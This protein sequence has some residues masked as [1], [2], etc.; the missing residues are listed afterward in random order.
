M[1]KWTGFISFSRIAHTY[2]TMFG[3]LG[4]SFFAFTGVILNH[5]HWFGLDQV[6]V[7]RVQGTLPPGELHPPDKLA[8]VETLRSRFGAAGKLDAMEIDD[9]RITVVFLQPGRRSEA[10]ITVENGSLEMVNETTGLAGI[11]SDLHK[12]ASTGD[13]WKLIIDL[14]AGVLALALLTGLIVWASVRKRR[15]WGIL[16]VAAGIGIWFSCYLLLAVG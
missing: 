5:A 15:V 16:A 11:V 10:V 9:S 4:M 12:G 8:I 7:R 13:W 1:A 14:T 6:H 3:L 2:L